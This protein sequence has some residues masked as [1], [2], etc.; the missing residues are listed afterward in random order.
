MSRCAVHNDAEPDGAAP[1]P[2]P[3]GVVSVLPDS[4]LTLHQAE[5]LLWRFCKVP[6]T[7]SPSAAHAAAAAAGSAEPDRPRPAAAVSLIGRLG[8]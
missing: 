5:R 8:V 3:A 4:Y 2:P 6:P 7:P 1:P